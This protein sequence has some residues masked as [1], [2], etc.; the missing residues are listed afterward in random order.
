M[1]WNRLVFK[2]KCQLLDDWFVGLGLHIV[3]VSFDGIVI[4]LDD[5]IVGANGLVSFVVVLKD[6][7]ILKK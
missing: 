3:H 7:G 6:E 2:K 5:V 1:A 4:A